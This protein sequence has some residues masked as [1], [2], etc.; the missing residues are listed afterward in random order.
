MKSTIFALSLLALLT[1]CSDTKDEQTQT[2]TKETAAGSIEVSK[3]KDAYQTKVEE[4]EIS[5]DRT[6]YYEET[7]Q[8]TENKR[9]TVDANVLVRSPYEQ[10]EIELL[11]RSLSKEFIIKCSSCHNDYANGIVGPS[12]LDKDAHFINSTIAAYKTGEKENVLM[13]ELVKQMSDEEIM[14]LSEEIAAFNQ[15]IK[16]LRKR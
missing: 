12:L 13:T 7:K 14:A 11:V 8:Q 1:G 2:A 9:T 5:G 16:A 15:E 4:K 6:F 3:N 10:V